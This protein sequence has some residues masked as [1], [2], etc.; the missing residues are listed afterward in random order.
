MHMADLYP[1]GR[2]L[3][4]IRDGDLHPSHQLNASRMNTKAEKVRLFDVE[5]VEQA[6]G[7]IVFAKDMLRCVTLYLAR[8]SHCP[9]CGT[10]TSSHMPHQ[11]DRVL[12]ELL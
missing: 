11:Y 7:Q 1:P 6:F 3:W 2:V 8:A 4:A 12:H 10:Y 5:D 9:N